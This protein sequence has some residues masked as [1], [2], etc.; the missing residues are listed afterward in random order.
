[1][2]YLL[3]IVL[4]G[5]LICG[6]IVLD[7]SGGMQSTKNSTIYNDYKIV[8]INN[9]TGADVTKNIVLMQYTPKT[10]LSAKIISEA[11]KGTVMVI[12]GNGASHML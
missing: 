5:M 8:V 11:K 6:L 1:M 10:E 7:Q 2:K 4:L 12:F 3:V 9:N